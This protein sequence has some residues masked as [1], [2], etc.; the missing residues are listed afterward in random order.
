MRSSAAMKRPS[1][2]R[3]TW[4][5]SAEVPASRGT[6]SVAANRS[7]VAGASRVKSATSNVPTSLMTTRARGDESRRSSAGEGGEAKGRLRRDQTPL[8]AGVTLHRFGM[9]QDPSAVFAAKP[10][11]PSDVLWDVE[12]DTARAQLA[13]G[14]KAAEL[15]PLTALRLAAL[16]ADLLPPGVLNVVLGH[17]APVGVALTRHPQVALVSLTGDVNTGKAVATPRG[18]PASRR[19]S[20]LVLL[21]IISP[22][23]RRQACEAR[24]AAH[25]ARISAAMEPD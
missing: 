14:S 20:K 15:T 24:A 19:P 4:W 3:S 17:G 10:G 18:T 5:I 21:V 7:T 23:H 11:A 13:L 8:A 25:R 2:A 1:R 12:V 22:R 16:S 6:T 9:G